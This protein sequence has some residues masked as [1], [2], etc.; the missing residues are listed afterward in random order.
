METSSN[1][2]KTLEQQQKLPSVNHLV[3]HCEIELAELM[4]QVDLEVKAKKLKWEREAESL[5]QSL[6]S[7]EVECETTRASLLHTKATVGELKQR[8]ELAEGKHDQTAEHYKKEVS[9]VQQQLMTVKRE[10]ER[11]QKK[12]EKHQ[13]IVSQKHEQVATE[14]QQS[15]AEIQTLQQKLSEL[16]DRE[17]QHQKELEDS[18]SRVNSL[19]KEKEAMKCK[20]DL[21]EQQLQA[22]QKTLKTAQEDAKL[23]STL[24]SRLQ[25]LETAYSQANSKVEEQYEINLKLRDSIRELEKS[26]KNQAE[27]Y[28]KLR[29]DSRTEA[30]A[31][32]ESQLL[33][34]L[35]RQATSFRNVNDKTYS[36]ELQ[37]KEMTAKS[38]K[39]SLEHDSLLA[40]VKALRRENQI[41]K[42]TIAEEPKCGH[43][44]NEQNRLSELEAENEQLRINISEL[45]KTQMQLQMNL[46][47]SRKASSALPL[48]LVEFQKVR[49]ERDE[50]AKLANRSRKAETAVADFMSNV[51]QLLSDSATWNDNNQLH[52]G[53][54]NKGNLVTEKFLGEEECHQK[55]LEILLDSHMESLQT[56]AQKIVNNLTK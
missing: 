14:Q 21:V 13:R 26:Y 37:L 10:H 5:K 33:S 42:D 18:T 20:F 28:H 27:K 11:L 31:E 8:L 2:W 30:G 44:H 47:E 56:E 7:K 25:H 48:V 49:T 36:L 1:L 52:G 46:S 34:L 50:L 15:Q 45:E 32:K 4:K 22:L 51:Q 39:Q 16:K 54:G 38:E 35:Q 29:E 12:H 24:K 17:A 43:N 23:C 55:R 9:A 53:D 40:E 6:K 19:A 41:L 3:R